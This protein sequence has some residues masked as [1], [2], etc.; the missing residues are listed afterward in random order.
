MVG[1]M[2]AAV[3]TTQQII[4]MILQVAPSAQLI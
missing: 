2:F 1:V 3:H 4:R